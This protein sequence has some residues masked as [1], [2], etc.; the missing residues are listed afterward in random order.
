VAGTLLVHSGT[1]L[2]CAPARSPSACNLIRV[3]PDRTS[4]EI[5]VPARGG[6][7]LGEYPRVWP[8]EVVQQPHGAVP[9]LREWSRARERLTR[10]G[11]SGTELGGPPGDAESRGP[12][13]LR[14]AAHPQLSHCRERRRLRERHAHARCGRAADARRRP[15]R[16]FVTLVSVSE[17]VAGSSVQRERL[18]RS[19]CS[20]VSRSEP[21]SGGGGHHR[22]APGADGGDDLFG[23]DAL[24]VDAA[25]RGAMRKE[26]TDEHISS[27]PAGM[28]APG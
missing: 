6:Q 5:R 2:R 21:E 22:W 12:E 28:P 8:R 24:Q 1:V 18:R 13:G 23:V 7:S 25:P 19:R 27:V 16:V 15:A 3:R 4:I 11:R 14:R 20:G 10:R 9:A 26:M 17:A